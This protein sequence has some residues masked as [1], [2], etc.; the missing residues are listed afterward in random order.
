M[1]SGAP[2]GDPT[3]TFHRPRIRING[4]DVGSRRGGLRLAVVAGALSLA[5]G[6]A[7][8]LTGIL[9]P[10]AQRTALGAS[11]TLTVILGAPE[12]RTSGGTFA[13]V[14]DGAVLRA[15]DAVRTGPGTRVVLTYF[16][17]S[18]VAIEPSSELVIEEASFGPEGTTLIKMHQLVGHT[19]HVV[20]KLVRGG[21]RY[22]VTTP[23]S[24]ATVRGT[25]FEVAVAPGTGETRVITAEGAVATSDAAGTGEVL[26]TPGLETVVRAGAP[27]APPVLTP[28]PARKVRVQ[29]SRPTRSCLTRS[30]ARTG[31]A[32]AKC[33][34]KRRA[35]ASSAAQTACS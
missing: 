34:C 1:T 6:L 2:P 4:I 16:E 21:S 5:I 17:G 31:C 28:E 33:C 3:D 7:V 30:A 11:I 13:P 19:W 22:E 18:T 25:A 29:L 24:T 12:A 32:T 35:R 14:S 20:T 26:V 23:V 15:G 10:P 27:P 9:V 8:A